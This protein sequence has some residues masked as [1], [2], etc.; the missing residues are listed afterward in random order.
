[1]LCL[2]LR[3]LELHA[4]VTPP[5]YKALSLFTPGICMLL[6]LPRIPFPPCLP[7]APQ[8]S[9]LLGS[10]CR[11][12]CLYSLPHTLSSTV[13]CHI[14][15]TGCSLLLSHPKLHE[16][17]RKGSLCLSRTSQ[18]SRTFHHCSLHSVWCQEQR[19][20]QKVLPHEFVSAH[21]N[22]KSMP[23]LCDQVRKMRLRKVQRPSEFLS[24]VT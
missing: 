22:A 8:I 24:Q 10:H 9:V 23:S 13:I 2:P 5:T 11:F 3:M 1:M 6:H 4:S 21:E 20:P 19:I 14:Q 7:T 15:I 17:L 16:S 18:V 12:S